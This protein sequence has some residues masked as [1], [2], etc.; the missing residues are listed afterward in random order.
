MEDPSNADDRW[1][2]ARAGPRARADRASTATGL[3]VDELERAALDAV[4]VTPAHQQPDR[5]RAR[6]ERRTALLALA[7]RAARDRDRGRLRRRVPL[8]PR[9]RRRAAGPRPRARRLRRL[10][11]QDAR[12]RA[13]A[14]LARA[15]AGAAR[16]RRATRSSWPTA[17]RRAS[18]S[19]RS[20]TSSRAASSTATC[21]ACA[22]A[23]AAA[24]RA[25]A[26]RS[27][28]E[29]PEATVTGIAAGLHV[30]VELAGQRRRARDPAR[31][32]R[33]AESGS[34]RCATTATDGARRPADADAR[35]R[36]DAGAGD[37]R[38]AC[39]RWRTRCAPRPAPRRVRPCPRDK[40]PPRASPPPAS[41][42]S[43]DSSATTRG[44]ISPRSER[45]ETD[46]RD[47]PTAL[48]AELSDEFGGEP[49]AFRQQRDLGFTPSSRTSATPRPTTAR[50]RGSP[51]PSP[52]R[53][54][55]PSTSRAAACTA[56]PA[57]TRAITRARRVPALT[58]AG[59][60]R[61]RPTSAVARRA[62]A[63]RGSGTEDRPARREEP[64]RAAAAAR[65]E[66]AVRAARVRGGS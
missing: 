27:R 55:P 48:L 29:L 16:R 22:C 49:R 18:S 9:R 36:A 3:R 25:R 2:V 12:A 19:T 59:L 52:A 1:I 47:G 37:R 8:R 32:P 45:C 6:G 60:R 38:P 56:D 42:G 34:R 64:D 15:A 62:A 39:A 44:P 23:T 21:A 11:Q 28:G 20:P 63:V 14:R 17:A 41:T 58:S 66:D 33:A 7:A 31:R 46:V 10:G 57:A 26:R 54:T 35:L 61:P 53:A 43:P 50:V 40:P 24:R 51:P 13:A 30:I 5:R 4:V 65:S